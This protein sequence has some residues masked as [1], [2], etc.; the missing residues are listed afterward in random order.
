MSGR[1]NRSGLRAMK[2]W[3]DSLGLRAYCCLLYR[4]R[5]VKRSPIIA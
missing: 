2:D 3:R 1:Y 5:R 4:I